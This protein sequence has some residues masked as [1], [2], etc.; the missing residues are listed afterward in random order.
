MLQIIL[1]IES[2]KDSFTKEIWEFD[3]TT[4]T[5]ANSLLDI[6]MTLISSEK[7]S[8]KP[9]F[10]IDEFKNKHKKFLN[11]SHQD[12]QEFLR[13]L[14]D[15]LSIELNRNVLTQ[16]YKEMNHLNKTKFEL[17]EEYHRMFVNREDSFI[18]DLF[19]SQICNTFIC[20][21]CSHQTFSFEKILDLPLL[22]GE[23]YTFRCSYTDLLDDY[24]KDEVIDWDSKC[25]KCTKRAKHKKIS[26]ISK[27]PKILVITFQRYNFRTGSKNN[28]IINFKENITLGKYLEKDCKIEL[29]YKLTAISNHSGKINF[30]HYFA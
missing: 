21:S 20:S 23:N 11:N 6:M 7:D 16:G 10:I 5:M 24:F 8:I 18:V 17:N 2:F 14:L 3:L 28:I 29:K 27:L 12:S 25:V 9:C 4:K 30:G 19:H 1:R 13:L 22:I 15:D 26:R